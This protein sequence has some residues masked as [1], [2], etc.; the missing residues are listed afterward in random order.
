MKSSF[1]KI[2]KHF[3]LIST[4]FLD[5]QSSWGHKKIFFNK[6][7]SSHFL[8]VKGDN[9]IINFEHIKEY[10]K[11]MLLFCIEFVFKNNNILFISYPYIKLILF[12]SARSLGFCNFGKWVSGALTNNILKY[13][14]ILILASKLKNTIILKESSKVLLPIISFEDSDYFFNKSNY[15]LLLNDDSKESLSNFCLIFTDSIIK[16]KLFKYVKLHL[17]KNI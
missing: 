1:I 8:G 15:P 12:F 7:S 16:F 11:R 17:N 9:L 2:S 6:S 10:I 14:N 5:V 3:N 13:H 4:S